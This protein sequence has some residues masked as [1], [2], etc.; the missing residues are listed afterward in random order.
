MSY[1]LR[2]VVVT[3]LGLIAIVPVSVVAQDASLRARFSPTGSPTRPK[4][5]SSRVRSGR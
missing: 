2:R 3:I 5:W 1:T 4:R